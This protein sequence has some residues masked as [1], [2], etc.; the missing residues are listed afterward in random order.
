MVGKNVG[1]KCCKSGWWTGSVS[2]M[3]V[4]SQNSWPW[5]TTTI[6]STCLFCGSSR[7]V[8]VKESKES[9]SS[10]VVGD[11]KKPWRW[12]PCWDAIHVDF[13]A[14]HGDFMWISWQFMW[15]S[16]GFKSFDWTLF[17]IEWHGGWDCLWQLMEFHGDIPS[18]RNGMRI[19]LH[20]A[21]ENHHL[22]MAK[23]AGVGNLACQVI[24]W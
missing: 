7:S 4:S 24:R 5:H 22:L 19:S 23:S 10:R 11:G 3:M 18:K 8:K 1:I 2:W 16:C 12:K 20:R 9:N 6:H 15:I 21:M 17:W 13:M 14:I